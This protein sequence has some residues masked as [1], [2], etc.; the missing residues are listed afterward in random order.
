MASSALPPPPGSSAPDADS[1]PPPSAAP[2]QGATPAPATPSPM[3]QQG[4]QL[5]LSVVN[6]LRAIAKQFPGAAPKVAEAN[7]LMREIAQE[8][9]KAAPAPEAQAPPMAG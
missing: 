8:I 4:T 1:A 7:N 9:M 3:M 5:L 6:N 2:T